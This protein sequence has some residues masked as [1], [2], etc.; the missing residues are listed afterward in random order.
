MSV[1][2]YLR[3]S[4]KSSAESGIS[5]ENQLSIIRQYY[6]DRL[7]PIPLGSASQELGQPGVLVD[8]AVS[9]WSKKISQRAG[10]NVLVS[11]LKAG[12]HVV[13]Y[14][15]DRGFRNLADWSAN[16]ESWQKL[17]ITPHFVSEGI[18]MSNA[19][20]RA[21]ANFLAVVAQ[22][23][24]DLNSERTREALLI[25]RI[26]GGD[27]TKVKDAKQKMEWIGSEYDFSASVKKKPESLPGRIFMYERCSS[28]SQY[29]S[30]LGL[31]VQSQANLR[32][33]QRLV[34]NRPGLSL[35]ETPFSDEAVSAFSIGFGDR[36]A[37]KALLKEVKQGDHIVIYRLDRAWRS[38][39]D[40]VT[41][42]E[43]M[44]KKGVT[45]H[46]V[47]ECIE[48]TSVHGEQFVA[49]LATV[50]KIES[51][52]KSRRKFEANARCKETGRPWNSPPRGF[53]M[54]IV[55]NKKKLV[56]DRQQLLWMAKC[57]VIQKELKYGRMHAS[58]IV[59]AIWCVE[60]GVKK[61]SISGCRTMKNGCE[62][63]II[64]VVSS[65]ERLRAVIPEKAYESVKREARE[66]IAGVVFPPEL[67]A[68][69]IKFRPKLP[70]RSLS[71]CEVDEQPQLNF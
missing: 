23:S 3:V 10:G 42:C 62:G 57:W 38:T 1:Y 21:M 22:L 2:F 6:Q 25:K 27:Y 51:Q 60:N 37:G 41:M 14:S 63:H 66:A 49:M 36:P 5:I 16:I 68:D 54:K 32:Y 29:I 47:K 18:D 45:I 9:G 55:D 59:H 50:A 53:K 13:F 52:I 67:I 35:H 19:V 43:E 26:N 70:L 39:K 69:R 20:G 34:D 71:S 24:S 31:E 28:Y 30:G 44:A 58:D 8:R 7:Y 17:G 56:A 65:F 48:A 4:H 46:L 15:I 12:D 11:N 33:A 40:A 61:M 64:D